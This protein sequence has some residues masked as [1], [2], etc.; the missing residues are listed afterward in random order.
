M[1]CDKIAC[2]EDWTAWPLN[3]DY[4]KKRKIY[5]MDSVSEI[6]SLSSSNVFIFRFILFVKEQQTTVTATA[7]EKKTFFFEVFFSFFIWFGSNHCSGCKGSVC[8]FSFS[9]WQWA[10]LQNGKLSILD[11]YLCLAIA[12]HRIWQNHFR[13]ISWPM[14]EIHIL[15]R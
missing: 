6:Y 15:Q 7:T 3:A 11:G 2:N 10:I 1:Q 12:H 9:Q 13:H 8:H 4:L 14:Y 5:R